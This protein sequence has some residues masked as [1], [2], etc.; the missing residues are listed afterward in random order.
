MAQGVFMLNMIFRIRCDC[1][2]KQ[3][4]LDMDRIFCELEADFYLYIYIY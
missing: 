1:F 4:S 3:H 2:P